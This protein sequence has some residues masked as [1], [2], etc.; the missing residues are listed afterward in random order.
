MVQPL[1]ILMFVVILVLFVAILMVFGLVFPPWMRALVRGTPVSVFDI[2]GMRLRGSP[3]LLLI[4][5]YSTLR[6]DDYS[7]TIGQVER[8][9]LGARNRI[10]TSD[11]LVELVK[12]QLDTR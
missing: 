3:P 5:A 1:L 9:Y 6:H 2:I 8:A 7:V 11:D 10:T 4:D 12:A